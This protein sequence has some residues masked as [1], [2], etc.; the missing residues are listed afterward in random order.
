MRTPR[1][2]P[3]VFVLFLFFA[4]PLAVHA[5]EFEPTEASIIVHSDTELSLSVD[6]DLIELFGAQFDM[7][8]DA[9]EMI[10]A[11]RSLTLGDIVQASEG[12]KQ[13]LKAGVDIF[14]DGTP[15]VLE[16]FSSLSAMRLVQLLQRDPD[17]SNYRAEFTSTAV[18]REGTELQ[19]RFPEVLGTVSLFIASPKQTLLSANELSNGYLM[20]LGGVQG[21]ST[22]AATAVNY[23]HHGFLHVLPY[24]LDHI[25]FVIALCLLSTRVSTLVWQI[26][27]FTLAHTLTLGLSSSGVVNLSDNLVANVVEPLIAL[28][29]AWVAFENIFAKK[30]HRW[31]LLIVFMFGLMHGLGFAS[32]LMSLGLSNSQWLTSLIFFNIGVELGQ[33]VVVVLTVA[34][35]YW[36]RDKTW[37]PKFMQMPLCIGIG[38]MG[39]YWVVERIFL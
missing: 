30:L 31:R 10:A 18:F 9:E 21:F 28:S 37:Y 1:L 24:G 2:I 38:L 25:L 17:S 33:I 12:V 39:L 8:G 29:I 36:W 22:K 32:A 14:V 27:I 11:V 4:L 16:E 19:V 20:A 15:V 13:E 7:D 5:H 26:S 34:A 35:T 6:V 23:A 3:A